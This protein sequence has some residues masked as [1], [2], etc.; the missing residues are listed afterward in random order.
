M[1]AKYIIYYR[2]TPKKQ[3]SYRDSNPDHRLDY[4]GSKVLPGIEPRLSASETKPVT[5]PPAQRVDSVQAVVYAA[6][7]I[8][9]R[10]LS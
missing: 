2:T 8:E 1:W 4:M 10:G 6:L 5:L 3:I 9:L 7:P